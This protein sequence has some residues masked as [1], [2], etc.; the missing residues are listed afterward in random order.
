MLSLSLTAATVVLQDVPTYLPPGTILPCNLERE[1]VRD[2][3]ISPVAASL[4]ELPHGALSAAPASA[5]SP[6]PAQI[7]HLRV[8]TRLCQEGGIL[9][10]DGIYCSVVSRSSAGESHAAGVSHSTCCPVGGELPRQCADQNSQ[11]GRGRCPGNAAGAGGPEEAGDG[12]Q[13]HCRPVH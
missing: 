4:G 7:P 3:F 1:D 9:T 5:A 10:P 8:C 2:A 13:G 6:D 12:R 11:A